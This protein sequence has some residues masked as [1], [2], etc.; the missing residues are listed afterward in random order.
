MQEARD[1]I[2]WK[3]RQSAARRRNLREGLVQLKE[4][5]V[6][7][8][9]GLAAIKARKR[10]EYEQ[11]INAP[12]REDEHLTT[13]SASATIKALGLPH[14]SSRGDIEARRKRY[15]ASEALKREKRRDVLHNLYVNAKDFIVSMDDLDAKI[16]EEFNKEFYKVN[17][18]HGI[19]DEQGIPDTTSWLLSSSL[20]NPGTAADQG[21]SYTEVGERV[22]RV[23]RELTGGKL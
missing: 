18:E 12:E 6:R 7:T 16:E 2:G 11:R 23:G 5:Q 10:A 17:P 4:R 9:R 20:K 15:E 13:P 22:Q 8:D 1:Y 19:W 21:K 14:V 3:S